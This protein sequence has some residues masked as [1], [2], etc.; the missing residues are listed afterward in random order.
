VYLRQHDQEFLRLPQLLT[1]HPFAARFR[2]TRHG[3]GVLTLYHRTSASGGAEGQ[4]RVT[5]NAL[6]RLKSVEVHVTE[7]G[8]SWPRARDSD[9]VVLRAE[10]AHCLAGQLKWRDTYE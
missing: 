7:P 10:Y 9:E 2:K 4:F 8:T 6:T 1:L 3:E 5:A